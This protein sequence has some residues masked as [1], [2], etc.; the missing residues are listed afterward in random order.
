LAGNQADY[1][2]AFDSLFHALDTFEETLSGQR[3]LLGS[4]RTEPDWRAFACLVRFDTIYYS[5]YKCNH[6]R[7]VDYPHLWAYTRDLY[8]LPGVAATVNLEK[9]KAGYYGIINPGGIVAKGPLIDFN[10]PHGR[11]T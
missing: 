5:L 4:H 3:Y 10:E 11:D 6:K 9:I 1:D 8:Q 7:I 2:S